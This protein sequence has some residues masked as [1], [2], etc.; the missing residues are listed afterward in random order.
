MGGGEMGEEEETAE[1]GAVG[2]TPVEK[3]ANK[4]LFIIDSKKIRNWKCWNKNNTSTEGRNLVDNAGH[5]VREDVRVN[6]IF[7]LLSD[8]FQIDSHVLARLQ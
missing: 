6:K 5:I 8:D 7:L 2:R 4:Y 3:T 1:T